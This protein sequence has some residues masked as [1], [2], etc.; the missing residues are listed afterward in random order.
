MVA[1]IIP[2]LIA[3]TAGVVGR[4]IAKNGI[5]KAIKKY[6]KNAITEG[7]KHY[8][9]VI[10]K[11]GGKTAEKA[12]NIKKIKPVQAAN[13]N[14]RATLRKGLKI[15]GAGVAAAYELSKDDKKTT[16][17]KTQA[18]KLPTTKS[19]TKTYAEMVKE[20]KAK[21]KA[22]VLAR[23]DKNKK[24]VPKPIPKGLRESIAKFNMLTSDKK[25]TAEQRLKEIAKEKLVKKQ[26]ELVK[27]RKK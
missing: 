5:A 25:G 6:T 9:D 18:S 1:P 24:P 11:D 13:A 20:D 26:K 2:A 19:K 15:G 27:K 3:A 4:Y 16:K 10:K 14:S 8:A 23:R 22:K 12:A 21:G 17:D 7:K